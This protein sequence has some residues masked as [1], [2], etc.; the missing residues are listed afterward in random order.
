MKLLYGWIV[1]LSLLVIVSSCSSSVLN[2]VSNPA[3]STPKQSN[4][5]KKSESLPNK[6]QNAEPIEDDAITLSFTGDILLDGTVGEAIKK[7]GPDYPFEKVSPILSRAD[8]T[9]G[10]LET[11]VS[12]RG[13]PVDKSYTFRSTPESLNG[14]VNAG[15]DMVSLAN[16]HTLDYGS[17]ALYDTMDHLNAKGIG[18]S[19]AGRNSEEAFK[20]YYKTVKGKKIA[21]LGLSRVLP[22]ADWASTDN[23]EGLASAYTDEPMMHYVREAVNNA[24]YTFIYI[25][26]NKERADY[27]EDY[28]R[29]LARKFIDAGVSG[30]IGSHSHSLM[31][32]EYY[33][34]AP[35]YY[36]L[37]NFVFTNSH[38]PKGHESMIA[39]FKIEDDQISTEIKPL[40][41]I[42]FQP[43]PI[44]EF[45]NQFLIDKIN[46]LSYN[47]QINENGEV[48]ETSQ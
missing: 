47:V 14:L 2:T 21:I 15:Y 6:E 37:G 16:N 39:D 30:V 5:G 9:I 40:N 29:E 43:Q 17:E 27:P 34:G 13:V 48:K 12:T 1:T 24:D 11:S 32:I 35:I 38:N 26:W 41:I 19:G 22:F 33:K 3:S 4:E 25:H 8:L 46:R 23:R 45:Y 44:D 20:A 7:H 28:A 42:D 31:G 36:S 18:Y 10:N